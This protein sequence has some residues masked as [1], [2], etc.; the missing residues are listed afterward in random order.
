MDEKSFKILCDGIT[1]LSKYFENKNTIGACFKTA[2]EVCVLL[3][4]KNEVKEESTKVL[5]AEKSKKWME[6]NYVPAYL[7]KRV[8]AYTNNNLTLISDN[9]QHTSTYHN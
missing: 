5:K 9:P 2:F 7:V 6:Q 8:Y 1:E 3:A 4:K